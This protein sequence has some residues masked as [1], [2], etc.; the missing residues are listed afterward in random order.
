MSA[1]TGPSWTTSPTAL[2]RHE[3]ARITARLGVVFPALEPGVVQAAVDR[4]HHRF[5]ACRVRTYVP[6]LVERLARTE[7]AAAS[8]GWC[9]PTAGAA[10]ALRP[11]RKLDHRDPAPAAPG[12]VP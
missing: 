1:T 8:S 7:L 5:Q 11:R 3:L 10:A 2:E 12:E 6:L 9:P 4:L